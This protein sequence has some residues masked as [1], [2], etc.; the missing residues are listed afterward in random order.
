VVPVHLINDTYDSV[1]DSVKLNLYMD[2]VL[3]LSRSVSY[4]L[5]GLGKEIIEMPVIIPDKK[6]IYRMEAEISYKGELIKSIR[7]FE[8]K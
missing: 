4:K 1:E 8:V 3:A 7:E 6:G 2:N 5:S